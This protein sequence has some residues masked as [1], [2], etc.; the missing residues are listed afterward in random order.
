MNRRD[1]R[2]KRGNM[3]SKS[4]RM[5]TRSFPVVSRL[6][7]T[8]GVLKETHENKFDHQ[9]LGKFHPDNYPSTSLAI[10]RHRGDT[11]SIVSRFD[12]VKS[13]LHRTK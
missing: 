5:L 12:R 13:Q 10:V 9:L 11:R 3:L 8:K 7:F 1:S 4:S 6:S 2:S